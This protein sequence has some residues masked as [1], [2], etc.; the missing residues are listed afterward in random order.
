MVFTLK[1]VALVDYSGT[2]KRVFSEHS[3]FLFRRRDLIMFDSYSNIFTRRTLTP[4]SNTKKSETN[5]DIL[6]NKQLGAVPHNRSIFSRNLK[7]I[8]WNLQSRNLKYE[9]NKFLLPE[10]T[11]IF[12]GIDIVCLQETKHLIKFENFRCF[13]SLRPGG[14]KRVVV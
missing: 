2:L 1:K 4:V 11:N 13:N 6:V 8:S 10:F 14:G 12:L 9:G 3:E 5:T 7:I